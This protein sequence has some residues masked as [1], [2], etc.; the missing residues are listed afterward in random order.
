MKERM[1]EISEE[2]ISNHNDT[3]HTN[4]TSLDIGLLQEEC[5][6]NP[7][8][9]EYVIR[10]HIGLPNTLPKDK[11]GQEFPQSILRCQKV[12][13]DFHAACLPPQAKVNHLNQHWPL[14]M[15]IQLLESGENSV[16]VYQDMKGAM[17]TQSV[18][19]PGVSLNDVLRMRK[20]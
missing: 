3:K 19:L 20:E 12:N 6:P 9:V 5:P 8:I 2:P 16:N 10:C 14:L 11:N 18:I 15:D 13:G 1:E 17:F 7:D 4:A